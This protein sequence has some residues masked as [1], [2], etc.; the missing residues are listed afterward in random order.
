MLQ[1][2]LD[3]LPYVGVALD[4]ETHV[5]QPGLPCPPIVCGSWAS[6]ADASG[7]VAT[8]IGTRDEAINALKRILDDSR[9]TLVNA[10]IAF[11]LAVILHDQARRGIDLFPQ[12][13]AMYDPHRTVITGAVDGRVYDPQVAEALHAVSRGHLGLD[14][15][16]MRM[17]TSPTTGKPTT[18]YSLMR[19][20]EYVLGRLD[21]KVNDIWRMRYAELEHIPIDQ[22]P[23]EAR[24]YPQDDVR[25]ALL[26]ALGQQ[27]H[28]PAIGV[29]YWEGETCANCGAGH[30]QGGTPCTARWRRGNAHEISRQCYSDFTLKL[31]GYSG[32]D[33]DQEAV[34]ELEREYHAEHAERL[35][36]LQQAGF[37]RADGSANESVI[38]LAVAV[39]Y[40]SHLY[41]SACS[42]DGK[43][44]SPKTQGRTRINCKQCDGTG[45]QLT[46]SVPR[47]ESGEVGIGRDVLS[48]S[49]NEFL[50]YYAGYKEGAKIRDVYVPFFRKSRVT[51]P[52]GTWA[53]VPLVLE[54]NTI[55]ETGRISY[56]GAIGTLPRAGKIRRCIRARLGRVLSSTDYTAGELVTHAQSC[57][58]ITGDSALAYALNKGLDPHLALAATILGLDYE[59]AKARYKLDDVQ[60]VD[61]RQASKPGNFGFP[62][63]MGAFKLVL[64]QRKNGPD[65]A[66]PSGPEWISGGPGKPKV[67]GYKGLRFCLLMTDAKRCGEVLVNNWNGR[68]YTQQVCK[69]CLECATTVKVN[70]L[71]QWP[72][73]KP[74]QTHVSY[75]EKNYLKVIHHQSKRVRGFRHGLVDEDGEPITVGNAIANGYFQGLLADIAK[76][77]YCAAARECYDRTVIVRS[78]TDDV[79]AYEGGPSPLLGTRLPHLPHDELLADHPEDM[80]HDGSNRIGELMVES[81]RLKCP[82][83]YRAAKAK[84]ALM[85]RLYKGAKPVYNAAGKLIP[86]EPPPE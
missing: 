56:S 9:W 52:D 37:I 26:A 62:G 21:A 86:W 83:L 24:E 35:G 1:Q 19:V 2:R 5:M 40:G 71:K 29:H 14:P 15:A 12:V 42:G 63:R 10:N 70:W 22:W 23:R 25:N 47:T 74:Y 50:R 82:D 33:V 55:L 39:A 34:D 18:R 31:G 13:F 38:K 45:R 85:R 54:P 59:A 66:H 44:P 65:T 57:L 76:D 27:G 41:C 73:N 64:Q 30:D 17:M 58:W 60:M 51:Y 4:L 81:M 84:P 46:E 6:I 61:V 8:A 20:V 43:V 78:F 53:D 67:R 36:P 7:A 49:G 79:S 68:T 72:E 77:A 11:D 3:S 32:L 48:E 80:A 28:V 75:L 69:R 16:T